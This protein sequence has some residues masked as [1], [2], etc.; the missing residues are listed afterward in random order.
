ML[1]YDFGKFV[2]FEW[3]SGNLEHIKK[4]EVDFAECEEVFF[5]KPLYL[6]EDTKHSSE[7]EKRYQ[8]LG[9]TNQSRRMFLAFTIR[10][11]MI[12]VLSARDQNKKERR[13]YEKS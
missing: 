11:N 2:G 10:N 7:K 4:H 8:V 6:N 12:R 13:V 1:Y 5:N 9:R 3:N